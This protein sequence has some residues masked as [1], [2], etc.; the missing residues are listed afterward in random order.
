MKFKPQALFALVVLIFF[1]VFVYEAKEWRMQARLYPWSIGIP[2]I[3][4]A[5]LYIVRELTGKN[6][7]TQQQQAANTPVDFQ[8]TKGLDQDTAR[9][10]TIYIF[11]WI[12]GF[13]LG[14]WLI[15][16]S[17][18]VPLFVFL[19][20]KVQSREKWPLSIALTAGAWVIFWGLFDRLLRLPFPDGQVMVWLGLS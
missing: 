13:F 16:F 5:G 19:Y 8:F 6:E 1:I 15:G 2:M 4:L 11:G 18:M 10:R 7:K 17:Y 12:F 3:F 20:L 14:I 9:K